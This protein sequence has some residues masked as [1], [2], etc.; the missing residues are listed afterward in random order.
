MTY[1]DFS[2]KHFDKEVLFTWKALRQRTIVLW[3]AK[4]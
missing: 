3:Q 2:Y 4:P 1:A